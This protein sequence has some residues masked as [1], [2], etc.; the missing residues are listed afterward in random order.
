MQW[1][2]LTFRIIRLAIV[3]PWF[4]R[5]DFKFRKI[6]NFNPQYFLSMLLLHS[7]DAKHGLCSRYQTR[8][9]FTLSNTAHVHAIK[10]GPCSRYQTQPMFTLSNTAYVHAIK[11]GLCSCYQT[12]PMFTLS[13]ETAV[14]PL[15]AMTS[16][17]EINK[18]NTEY[19]HIRSQKL[20]VPKSN[21][22]DKHKIKLL[23][24]NVYL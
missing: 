1:I 4:V 18:M 11:H 22:R 19:I 9:M 14:T 2:Q 17:N 10:H 21:M 7:W 3:Y 6:K 5:R 13:K 23:I 12:R 20:C 16:H 24:I 8:P 15:A